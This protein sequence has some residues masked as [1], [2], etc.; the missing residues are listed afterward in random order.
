MPVITPIY[1]ALLTLLLIVLSARVIL[2]RRRIGASLGDKGDAPLE[3]AIRAQ[4]NLT[5][6]APF[7]LIL[8]ALLELQSAPALPLHGLG[9]LLVVGRLTHAVALSRTPQIMQMR[10]AGMVM[11]LT[12]LALAALWTLLRAVI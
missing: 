2:A 1:A 10:I 11:T 12:M 9:L 8:M 4:G 3:K 7:G 6:Y 5:E